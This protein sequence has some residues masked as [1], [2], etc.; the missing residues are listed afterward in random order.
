MRDIRAYIQRAQQA[1]AGASPL[2]R[3]LIQAMAVRYGRAPE[4]EQQLF[5]TQGAALC[6]AG[7]PANASQRQDRKVDP[8]DLGYA[9]A[10]ADVLRQFPNDPDVVAL[11]A[12]AVMTTMAW[13]W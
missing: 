10:M 2:E 12:D 13:E 9:A 7:K 4:R 5:E 8:Q 11:Y 1:A 3:A 6:S